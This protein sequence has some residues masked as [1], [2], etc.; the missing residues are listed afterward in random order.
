MSRGTASPSVRT[1][2]QPQPLPDRHH[3]PRLGLWLSG[4]IL[5][6]WF[7]SLLALLGN[8][9][10]ALPLWLVAVAVPLRA[11]LQTGLFIVA[12]DAMHGSLAP[13]APHLNER[14]GKFALLLYAFLPWDPCR[15]NHL[16]HHRSPGS[17]DDPDHHDGIHRGAF[18]WYLRFMAGYLAPAQM[19]ALLLCWLLVTVLLIPL[20]ATPVRNVLVFWTLP[21]LISS[22]QLFFF[23]TYL[24]HRGLAAGHEEPHCPATLALPGPLSLLACYH[25]GYHREHHEHPDVPWFD[26][27]SRTSFVKERFG[28]PGALAVALC[29][30]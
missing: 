14:M 2:P 11:F 21:L 7:T 9:F 29:N 6:A 15:R 5:A 3:R 28:Q 24:P 20:T 18:A 16:R 8:D 12:H 19:A 27:P 13:G 4:V 22:L 1:Q 23:G 25:F 10:D 26:L 30:R 17:R